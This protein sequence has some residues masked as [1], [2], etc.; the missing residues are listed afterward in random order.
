MN[1]LLILH[2]LEDNIHITQTVRTVQIPSGH[3]VMMKYK[4]ESLHLETFFNR[5]IIFN[6][7]GSGLGFLCFQNRPYIDIIL[8]LH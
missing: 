6:T 3:T 1:I 5:K 8:M 4:T 2:A 7:Y